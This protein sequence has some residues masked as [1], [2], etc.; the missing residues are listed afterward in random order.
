MFNS[1]M[2]L[3][4]RVYKN[5]EEWKKRIALYINFLTVILICSSI[6]YFIWFFYCKSPIPS[7]GVIIIVAI[8][9]IMNVYI[10]CINSLLYIGSQIG[11]QKG[12]LVYRG[13]DSEKATVY[14]KLKEVI[15]IQFL[16]IVSAC[17]C[18][19]N[20]FPNLITGDWF[21]YVLILIPAFLLE[22]ILFLTHDDEPTAF[23]DNDDDK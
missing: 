7:Y 15:T 23:F 16:M 14:E 5:N 1:I 22:S 3:A 4:A 6:A 19:H 12:L 9:C 8:L 18:V 11:I 2:K 17:I 20:Y 10:G 21:K 13:T